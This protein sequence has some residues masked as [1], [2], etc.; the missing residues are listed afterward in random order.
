VLKPGGTVAI[1][2]PANDTNR[3]LYEFHEQI[4]GA[5][6]SDVDLMALGYV[7][8]NVRN[9]LGEAGFEDVR[10][11][12]FTNPITF[13]DAEAFI[14]YWKNTSLFIRTVPE[15]EREAAV[16]RGTAAL[17]NRAEPMVNTKRV[18]IAVARKPA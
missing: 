5:K 6:P 18:A 9:G 3:E 2:G 10:V 13:P 15:G 11:E 8:E 14:T 17:A 12:I 7:E 1:S 16:Q 4:T